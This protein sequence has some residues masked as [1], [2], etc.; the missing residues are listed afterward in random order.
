MDIEKIINDT[1]TTDWKDILIELL[2]P[3]KTFMNNKLNEYPEDKILPPKNNIFRAFNFFNIK[4]LKCII[5]GQDCYH[6]KNVANGLCFS[7]NKLKNNKLQPSL[8]N[9]FKELNR[10]NNSKRS[11]PNLSDWAEQGCLLINMAL[12]VLEG[13][14]NSHANIWKNYMNDILEWIGKNCNNI[15]VMLW[16]NFAKN[17]EKYFINTNNLVLKAGHPSPLNRKNP[18]IGCNHFEL[19]KNIKFI[20]NDN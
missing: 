15:C 5:I 1:V 19:C 12:T 16:G 18:F 10:T 14:A 20:K 3:Y 8:N 11:D 2:E 17:S 7:H 13:H 4:D 6:T 9:I